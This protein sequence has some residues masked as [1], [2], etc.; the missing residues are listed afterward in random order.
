MVL[1]GLDTSLSLKCAGEW[2]KDVGQVGI[3]IVRRRPFQRYSTV[4]GADI[5][6][7]VEELH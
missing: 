5:E 4:V 2:M 1:V 6:S 7:G 3:E